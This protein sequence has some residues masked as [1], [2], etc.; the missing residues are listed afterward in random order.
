M[1]LEDILQAMEL[2]ARAEI[3][4][5][6]AQAEAEAA[7]IAA[8]AEEEARA[9]NERHH[10]SALARLQNERWRPIHKAR[11]AATR[12]VAEAR[13]A[14]IEEAFAAAGE[15][16]A[17]LR[18]SPRYPESFRRLVRE[19]VN[20]LGPRLHLL[21]DVRDEA[22]ARRI[23]AEMGLEA[24]ISTGLKTAGGLEASTLDGRVTVVNTFE[25]RL[26]LGRSPLRGRIASLLVAEG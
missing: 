5:V 9:I 4:K 6:M 15:E 7:S 3:E 25:S 19:I 24:E 21:V 14:L 18:Q 11:F 13:E 17:R 26:E 23:A 22:L 12:E 2:E 1:A 10:S 20:E 8:Q 16:L